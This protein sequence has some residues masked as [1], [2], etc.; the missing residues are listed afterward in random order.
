[1]GTE[2]F[3]NIV[4]FLDQCSHQHF[5]QKSEV[6]L[7]PKEQY[8]SFYNGD[9]YIIYSVSGKMKLNKETITSSC[10]E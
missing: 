9:L 8:G 3:P 5:L 4:Q 2:D 10:A 1:M 6:I 7:V